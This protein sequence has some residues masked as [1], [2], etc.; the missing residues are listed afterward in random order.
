MPDGQDMADAIV[1]AGYAVNYDG[2]RRLAGAGT[3]GK[4]PL[5]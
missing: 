4:T 5:A 3:G 2:G 1:K